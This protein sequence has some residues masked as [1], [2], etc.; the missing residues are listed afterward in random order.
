MVFSID[1]KFTYSSSL[2]PKSS[3]RTVNKYSNC[4]KN[5][6]FYFCRISKYDN[7]NS[8]VISIDVKLRKPIQRSNRLSTLLPT[9]NIPIY[10]TMGYLKVNYF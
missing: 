9:D 5:Q 1:Y 6:I 7:I 4:S 2:Y 10:I 3:I 8:H